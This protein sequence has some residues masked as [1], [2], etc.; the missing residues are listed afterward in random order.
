MDLVLSRDIPK[1]MEQFPHEGHFKTGVTEKMVAA[2]PPPPSVLALTGPPSGTGDL[3][4]DVNPPAHQQQQIAGPRAAAP[5]TV[6]VEAPPA[7]LP[8][9]KMSPPP[10]LPQAAAATSDPWAASSAANPFDAAPSAAWAVGP[11]EKAKY[12]EVF[13][14]LSPSGGKVGG[15]AV[16]PVLERSNLPVDALRRVWQLSDVDKDGQLD[17]DEFALAMHLVRLNVGGKPLPDTLPAELV[18]PSKRAGAKAAAGGVAE[19]E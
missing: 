1:L 8:Q 5:R 3:Y 18:P 7:P 17:A 19:L 2:L 11:A 6:S 13:V 4:G 10:A 14:T 15:A 16:R 12:D 9:L